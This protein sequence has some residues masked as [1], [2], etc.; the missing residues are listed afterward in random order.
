MNVYDSNTGYG[1]VLSKLMPLMDDVY[2]RKP[3]LTF[4]IGENQPDLFEFDGILGE[5]ICSF[6]PRNFEKGKRI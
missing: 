6:L 3:K 4:G 5:S 2:G 1:G